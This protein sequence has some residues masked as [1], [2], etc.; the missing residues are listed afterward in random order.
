M[1]GAG[2]EPGGC[3]QVRMQCDEAWPDPQVLSFGPIN[4]GRQFG[5]GSFHLMENTLVKPY[6]PPSKGSSNY[7]WVWVT[8]VSFAPFQIGAQGISG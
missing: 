6:P 7:A 3:A 2:A 5:G 4:P 8:L 1:E